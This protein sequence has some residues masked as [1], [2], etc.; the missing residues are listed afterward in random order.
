[1]R[2][3]LATVVA[4]ILVAPA[5]AHAATATTGAAQPGTNTATL[6]GTVNPEGAATEYYFQYGTGTTY[7]LQS[8]PQS[9]G[10]GTADVPVQATIS[11]LTA[12]TTYHYRLVAVPE[13]GHRSSASTAR[14][15]RPPPRRTRLRPRSRAS[16][17]ST[18]RRRR[19]G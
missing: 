16:P 9:A 6:N 12:S 13:G 18:R 4:L 5:T 7:G 8:S 3:L 2:M 17:P 11:G 14:S 19:H 15:R 1:M 10:S